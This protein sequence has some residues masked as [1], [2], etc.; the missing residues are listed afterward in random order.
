MAAAEWCFAHGVETGIGTGTLPSV[1]WRFLPLLS[2]GGCIGVLGARPETAPPPPQAQ[3]LATLAGQTALA[4]ERARISLQTART[5][6]QED[7][8]KLRNALLSS[9]SHDLRTPLTAIRGAAETLAQ[10]GSALD[11]ATRADLLA[12]ITQDTAR[13]TKFL[14]NIMDM[15]RVEAGGADRTAGA[16]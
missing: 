14:A 7:S 4:V 11:D 1:P 2:N 16:S 15:A 6:A 10:A 8:Q 3:T 12:S 13:M 5:Q 9:L